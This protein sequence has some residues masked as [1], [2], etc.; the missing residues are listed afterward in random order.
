MS[1][2]SHD[3]SSTA[4]VVMLVRS[5]SF[6]LI[7][8]WVEPTPEPMAS[9]T[10]LKCCG[11]HVLPSPLCA[12]FAQTATR[13]LP[14]VAGLGAY[15]Y[16]VANPSGWSTGC[17]G[18]AS[19]SGHLGHPPLSGHGSTHLLC[20]FNPVPAAIA[21]VVVHIVA[22]CRVT[23]GWYRGEASLVWVGTCFPGRVQSCL[24]GI[25]A[26]LNKKER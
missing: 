13:L 23:I 11:C 7:L 21:A 20:V 10:L 3:V 8:P 19:E 5:L 15:L 25:L 24:S 22:V 1:R 2:Y 26:L 4:A 12:S 17:C 14:L 9:A 16:S 6:L 18:G